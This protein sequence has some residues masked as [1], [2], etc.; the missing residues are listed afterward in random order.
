MTPN[1]VKRH[2][3]TTKSYKDF[4]SIF[5]NANSRSLL[6]EIKH[7]FKDEKFRKSTIQKDTATANDIKIAVIRKHQFKNEIIL[8]RNKLRIQPNKTLNPKSLPAI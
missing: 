7:T 1:L 2:E 5:A 6:K 8:S 4:H 3:L